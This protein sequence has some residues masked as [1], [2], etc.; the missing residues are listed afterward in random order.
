MAEPSI[1]CLQWEMSPL[2]GQWE[3][4]VELRRSLKPDRSLKPFPGQ[5]GLA[6]A[7][8]GA[9]GCQAQSGLY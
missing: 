7:E 8:V 4:L 1:L 9:R 2:L 6:G 5:A 3:G